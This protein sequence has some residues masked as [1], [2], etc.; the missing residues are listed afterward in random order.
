MKLILNDPFKEVKLFFRKKMRQNNFVFFK[1]TIL[2]GLRNDQERGDP[3]DQFTSQLLVRFVTKSKSHF[4]HTKTLDIIF[5]TILV[6]II[7]L[8]NAHLG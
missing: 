8:E 1:F 4:Y 5:E 3:W 7:L 2:F 6:V